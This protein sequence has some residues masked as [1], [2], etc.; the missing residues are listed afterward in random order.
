ML[1]R[2]FTKVAPKTWVSLSCQHPTSLLF[3]CLKSL[4]AAC[5]DLFSSPNSMKFPYIG[6][7]IVSFSPVH[8]PG[9]S[10]AKS[11]TTRAPDGWRGKCQPPDF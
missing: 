5:F 10:F 9:S 8:L 7:K 11:T 1:F 6:S 4:K 2:F 3:L